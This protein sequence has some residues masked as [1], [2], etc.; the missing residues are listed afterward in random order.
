MRKKKSSNEGKYYQN[1]KKFE[2]IALNSE[3][4]LKE[5]KLLLKL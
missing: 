3:G 5:M 4:T 1:E 2:I